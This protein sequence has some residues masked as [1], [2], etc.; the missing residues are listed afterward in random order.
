[1]AEVLLTRCDDFVSEEGRQ[2]L[3][4][5]HGLGLEVEAAEALLHGWA[6]GDPPKSPSMSLSIT[7]AV[8]ANEMNRT[9]P[10]HVS[11]IYTRRQ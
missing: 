2:L 4:G 7:R 8:R 6:H 5:G 10:S 3:F 11:L 1:M 9:F